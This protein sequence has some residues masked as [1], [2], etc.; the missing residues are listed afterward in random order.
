MS[1]DVRNAIKSQS[2][3]ELHNF[4]VDVDTQNNGISKY[5]GCNLYGMCTNFNGVCE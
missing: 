2:L 3:T 1:Q 5:F 4:F